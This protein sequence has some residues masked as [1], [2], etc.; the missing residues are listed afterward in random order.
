[1]KNHGLRSDNA[2]FAGTFL[3]AAGRIDVVA[4]SAAPTIR[5]TVHSIDLTR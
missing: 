1:M 5:I 3:V 2:T 4:I